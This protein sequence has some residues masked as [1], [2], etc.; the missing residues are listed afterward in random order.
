[1]Q[2]GKYTV[3]SALR[4]LAIFPHPDDESL[5]LGGTLAKYSAEGVET[6]LICATR[7]ERGWT[8]PSEE[9][10]GLE[11]LGKIREAELKCAVTHLGIKE[12]ILLNYIDGD[13]DKANPL[14]IIAKITHQIRRIQP[15][16]V[17]TFAMDGT[18]GHPDHIALSQFTSA[19]L[20]LSA[21]SNFI[22]LDNFQPYQVPKYYHMVD[23]KKMVDTL[24]EMIGGLSMEVDGVTRSHFGW[25]EWAITTRINTE[26]FFDTLWSAILCHQSQLAGLTGLFDIPA[27]KHKLL[28]S[29]GTFIRIY[30]FVNGERVIE[31][32]LFEGLR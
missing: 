16:V 18:Y 15:Q 3:N 29:E 20:V 32:D 22:D 30:S 5:G 26:E 14:E 9:N 25:E 4:L 24:Q 21:D 7:G 2:K 23:S 27:E 12:T 17:I 31:T 19:A 28:F 8:G 11:E 13:V 6:Y 1:L 10:P